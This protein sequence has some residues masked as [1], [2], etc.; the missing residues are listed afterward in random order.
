[1]RIVLNLNKAGSGDMYY[2]GSNLL[3]T[4]RQLIKD[5]E[6]WRKILRKIN[7]EFYHET[8]TTKQIEDFLSKETGIDLKAFFNQYLR[9]TM[10]PTLEYTVKKKT[11][12]YRWTTI[13]DG[14]DMPIQ[15][16]IN[17]KEQW[18]FPK[19]EWQ[20]ITLDSKI[21]DFEIDVD[22]YVESKQL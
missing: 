7:V 11:L 1:M 6:K 21:D 22:F 17:N 3:H 8:V 19:S 4:L 10:V 15:I 2:K 18:L 14:F 20:E 16:K 13:V 9:S 12:K 5:D